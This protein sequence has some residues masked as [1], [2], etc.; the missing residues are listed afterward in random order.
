MGFRKGSHRARRRETPDGA[1]RNAVA[2]PRGSEGLQFVKA[3]VLSREASGANRYLRG[4]VSGAT[5]GGF[6]PRKVDGASRKAG[7]QLAGVAPG[8]VPRGPLL[9]CH[10]ERME[11]DEKCALA[12]S[13]GTDGG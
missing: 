7:I 1:T 6:S 8:T 10:E 4:T 9:R 2:V 11:G 5:A 13:R 3:M 12:V